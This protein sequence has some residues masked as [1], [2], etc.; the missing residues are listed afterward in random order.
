MPKDDTTTAPEKLS[1][2]IALSEL[3]TI[4]RELERG[5]IALEES[6]ARF[7][8]GMALAR[9][10]EDRL[11]EAERK[12]AVLMKEGARLVERDLETGEILRDTENAGD[13][14]LPEGEDSDSSHDHADD[15][16]PF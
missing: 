4:V 15:E 5:E 6:I 13:E 3:D 7:E 10:C 8:R 11:N 16:L 9:R 12:V 1:F 2:E 14:V